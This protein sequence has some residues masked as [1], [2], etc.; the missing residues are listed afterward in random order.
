MRTGVH[1]AGDILSQ[2]TTFSHGVRIIDDRLIKIRP[3]GNF[4]AKGMRQRD[5]YCF[6]HLSY[7]SFKNLGDVSFVF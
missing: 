7:L 6:T 4:C 2:H 3:A 1:R 5:K